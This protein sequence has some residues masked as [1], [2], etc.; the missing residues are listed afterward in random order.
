MSVRPVAVVIKQR[1]EAVSLLQ[2]VET[3]TRPRR[4]IVAPELLIMYL[5]PTRTRTI[6]TYYHGGGGGGGGI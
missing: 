5:E 1:H 3:N 2:A 4:K 6:S